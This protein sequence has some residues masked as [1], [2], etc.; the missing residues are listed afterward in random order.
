MRRRQGNG[1]KP[2]H[3]FLPATHPSEV[4]LIIQGGYNRRWRDYVPCLAEPLSRDYHVGVVELREGLLLR[5]PGACFA[6]PCVRD[7]LQAHEIWQRETGARHIFYAAHSM[8]AAVAAEAIRRGALGVRGL[9]AMAA[10]PTLGDSRTRNPDTSVISIGQRLC[11]LFGLMQW[12]PAAYPI[13]NATTS[14]PIRF[15]IP[16]NDTRINTADPMVCQRFENLL[17]QMKNVS[18]LRIADRDHYFGTSDLQKPRFNAVEPHVII[19]DIRTTM[20]HVL[21]EAVHADRVY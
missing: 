3:G 17:R 13:R 14:V 12:G 2:H 8:G 1:L 9:Y 21:G 16:D 19:N 15:V 5:K 18:V 4:L 11:D 7:L 10:Y 20:N 6:G